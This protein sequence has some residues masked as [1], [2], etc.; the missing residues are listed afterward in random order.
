[1]KQFLVIIGVI[2]AVATVAVTVMKYLPGP[3]SIR[4]DFTCD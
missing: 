4:E 3:A 1:M 2:V